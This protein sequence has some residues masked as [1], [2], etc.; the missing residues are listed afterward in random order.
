M[1]GEES[2]SGGEDKEAEQRVIKRK[3]K[4]LRVFV[5]KA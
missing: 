3:R 1:R 2:G 5:V 4:R